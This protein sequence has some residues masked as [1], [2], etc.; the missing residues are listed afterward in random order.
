MSGT[1]IPLIALTIV[2]VIFLIVERVLPGRLLPRVQDWYLRAI[3][4][5]SAQAIISITLGKFWIQTLDGASIANLRL[6]QLPIV[7]GF[8]CWFVGTFIFYWWHRARH[9]RALWKIFHQV[10]HSPARIEVLTSFYKHPLEILVN[11]IISGLLVYGFFGTSIAGAL[12]YNFF[13]AIGEYFYHANIRTP[14]W[15]RI[16]IQT[17]ELHS[18]HHARGVH[19]FNYSDIPIWDKLFGTYK[20]ATAFVRECGFGEHVESRL[21]EMLLFEDVE[22]RK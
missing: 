14:H 6:W 18:I 21:G 15:L 20:D 3:V 13:A 16:F 17:P 9:T 7:E 12:W 1:S 4:I 2:T 22:T 10:H 8:F 11:A 5:N 19:A